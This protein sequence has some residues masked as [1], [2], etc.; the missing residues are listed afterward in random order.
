VK[1]EWHA[2]LLKWRTIHDFVPV[3]SAEGKVAPAIM[4]LNIRAGSKTM[5]S[6]LR[7]VC[8]NY[9]LANPSWYDLVGEIQVDSSLGR[10][11]LGA[12]ILPLLVPDAYGLLPV[13]DLEF[14]DKD[15]S[16]LKAF[17]VHIKLDQSF[18]LRLLRELSIS[19]ARK[20]VERIAA[21]AYMALGQLNSLHS[22][23]LKR[24][25]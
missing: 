10:Q 9:P 23:R 16:F 17:G 18:Y 11:P 4:D 5:L 24:L 7:W 22:A 13:L 3:I 21:S 15:W 6:Y 2:W 20:D 14:A 12:T 1:D 19:I 25:K 8:S